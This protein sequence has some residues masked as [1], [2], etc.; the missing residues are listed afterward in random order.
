MKEGFYMPANDK[1]MAVVREWVAK[2]ENDLTSA[3]YLLKMKDCPVDNVCFNAQQCVEKYLKA[4]LITQGLEFPKTHDL[5]EL[6]VLL[7]PRFRP[8]LDNQE[9]DKLTDYATVTR[10]PGDY[11]P[12]SVTEAQ[13]AVKIARRVQREVRKLLADKPLF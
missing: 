12:I 5:G 8:S 11:E 9:Q 6:L 7:P 13:Q 10:Y 1:A 2:A 3:A 4:L